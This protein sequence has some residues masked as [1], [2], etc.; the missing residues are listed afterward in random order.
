MNNNLILRILTG[1]LAGT[2]TVSVIVL[3]PYGLWLFCCLISLLGLWEIMRAT[4]VKVLSLKWLAM[5][6]GFGL[7]VIQLTALLGW[8]PPEQRLKLTYLSAFV[9]FPI[10]ALVALYEGSLEDPLRQLS[11]IAL[12]LVYVYLPFHLY[13]S[14]S[15]PE[16]PEEY[17]WQ[18]PLGILL[19]IWTL[20]S[21]AYFSGRWLGKH[22]L[23]PR[24]SPKKTWEGAIG[25]VLFCLLLG[26]GLNFWMETVAWDWI[27]AAV[28]VC[29]LGQWGDLVES[30]IKRSINLKDSGNILPGHGGILDRFDAFIFAVPFLFLYFGLL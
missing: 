2:I 19:L 14:M 16:L 23:F 27:I 3:S 6:G 21:M 10:M 20:D 28:I 8:L 25:G 9:W 17:D 30:M 18:L 26:V 5:A 13:Y 22:P 7:W 15:I 4:G 24:V 1:L 29:A 12:S 11:T